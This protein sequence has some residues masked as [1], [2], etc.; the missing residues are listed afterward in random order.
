VSARVVVAV[1]LLMV[2]VATWRWWTHPPDAAAELAARRAAL[3]R[4]ER[5]P[6]PD[7]GARVERWRLID[8]RGDTVLALWRPA[9]RAA[10]RAWTVVMLGGIGTG[11]RAA[12]LL[13]G[14]LD[15]NAL[16]V[17]WPWNG[18][19][20]MDALTLLRHVPALRA[21]LLRTP[22]CLALGLDA[23]A[24]EGVADTTRLALMGASLGAPPTVAAMRLSAA[25][26]AL[27]LVDGFAEIGASLRHGLVREGCPRPLATPLAA[28]GARLADPLEPAR[29]AAAIEVPVL[30]VNATRDERLPR[31]AVERL[32]ALLPAATVRWRA[33]THV[34]P[35]RADL[36]AG[37]AHEAAGWLDSLRAR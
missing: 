21:A 14:D 34:L 30:V 26:D 16:A 9:A 24:R 5:T 10:R 12:L 32:H 2:A 4:V 36:I 25:P 15:A 31:V 22:A 37:L 20:R 27:V 6:R 1:L 7:L 33:D 11:E 23:L 18:P 3:A 28:F 17:D 8:A 29:H 19:R 35:E 13:P